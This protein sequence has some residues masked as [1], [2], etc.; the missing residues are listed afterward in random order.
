MCS[1]S[2]PIRQSGFTLVELL[3]VVIILAILAAIVVPQ[4]SSATT[5]A[6]E[7]ALDSNIGALRS[8]VELY[9]AQHN[10]AYPGAV[11]TNA[12]A[13]C[14]APGAKGTAAAAGAQALIDELSYASDGNGNTCTVAD[15]ANGYKYGP[16][17]RTGIPNE[18]INK[19][20]SAVADIAITSTGAPIVPAVTTGGWA[21]DYKS[22]QIVMN[23]N[24]NDSKG[25]QYYKH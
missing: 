21:Y 25:V 23:S 2:N 13:G 22:G 9:K 14:A 3:I 7:A 24:A 19:K 4:F 18:T 20:G 17:L 12:G 1:R 15:T 5:D 16:Y 8:A 6:N 11:A 10:G